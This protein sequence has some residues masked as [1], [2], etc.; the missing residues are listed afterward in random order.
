MIQLKYNS[1]QAIVPRKGRASNLSGEEEQRRR[2]A[3]GSKPQ[4]PSPPAWVRAAVQSPLAVEG[5]CLSLAAGRRQKEGSGW[6][7][8][9][10]GERRP[11]AAAS[12]FPPLA[13]ARRPLAA[14]VSFLSSFPRVL[15]IL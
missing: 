4:R 12:S 10:A 1:E 13:A 2:E 6:S 3:E 5:Y 11:R 9:W 7:P 8:S 15:G 14:G